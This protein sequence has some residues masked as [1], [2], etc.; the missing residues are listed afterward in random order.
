MGFTTSEA[1]PYAGG[2]VYTGLLI[3]R[4]NGV[5][6]GDVPLQRDDYRMLAPG[7]IKVEGECYW[8]WRG[9]SWETHRDLLE[10]AQLEW[11]AQ[12]DHVYTLLLN[13]DEYKATCV[14]E[15]F[16]QPPTTHD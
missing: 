16:D 11:T 1:K 14:L 2:T 5:S 12:P 15:L 10:P 4:I 9:I 6:V 7:R 13:I 8:R 3:R